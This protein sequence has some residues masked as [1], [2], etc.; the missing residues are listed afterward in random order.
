MTDVETQP[1][2]CI[3]CR[4]D[5]SKEKDT[6]RL[7]C[8]K[9]SNRILRNLRELEEYLPHLS[10][11]K[12][13][14][15][16][17]RGRPGFGSSSPV[18]D[19]AIHHTDWR[20][21]PTALDG[22]GA[23]ATIHEWATNVREGRGMEPPASLSFWGEIHAL[24]HNHAW[25]VCQEWVGDYAA[26]LREIHAAVRAVAADPIPRS[27]GKC[28]GRDN[29]ECGADLYELPDASGVKCSDRSCGRVYS[30]TAMLRL[31]IANEHPGQE[32]G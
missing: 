3:T 13:R 8:F 15:D 31:Q 11:L 26:E 14:G 32:A 4:A 22:M 6:L 19:A 20:T 18:N 24:R 12:A 30:G 25:I 23:V 29:R 9:C 28:W 27:V 7:V 1:R 17:G 21:T 5:M 10:L 2:A 16:G